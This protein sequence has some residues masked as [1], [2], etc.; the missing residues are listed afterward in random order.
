MKTT[1]LPGCQDRYCAEDAGNRVGKNLVDN[2]IHFLSPSVILGQGAK[3]LRNKYSWGKSRSLRDVLA[4][5][6]CS[7]YVSQYTSD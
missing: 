1:R 4:L 7:H 6:G 5:Y 2:W 3:N